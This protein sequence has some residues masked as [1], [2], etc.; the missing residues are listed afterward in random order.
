MVHLCVTGNLGAN[1]DK[2]VCV[3]LAER[4][5]RQVVVVWGSFL[6]ETGEAAALLWFPLE[7]GSD[8]GDAR[9][10]G[11]VGLIKSESLPEL[12]ARAHTPAANAHTRTHAPVC[13]CF[14][15]GRLSHKCHTNLHTSYLMSKPVRYIAGLTASRCSTYAANVCTARYQ[16]HTG[17][18]LLLKG[19]LKENWRR[20]KRERNTFY[21]PVVSSFDWIRPGFEK[22]LRDLASGGEWRVLVLKKMLEIQHLHCHRWSVSSTCLTLISTVICYLLI[23]WESCKATRALFT[24]GRVTEGFF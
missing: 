3:C 1:E 20:K 16:V 17:E 6:S 2:F 21:H 11:G 14:I 24:E 18:G 9:E 22:C 12:L 5:S 8:G 7:P 19:S 4:S 15:A 23:F 13:G 10:W